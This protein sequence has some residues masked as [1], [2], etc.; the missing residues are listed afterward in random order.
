MVSALA[1][2][3]SAQ[4]SYVAQPG[5]GS[6]FSGKKQDN[7]TVSKANKQE[8][9][10]SS[11]DYTTRTSNW[12]VGIKLGAGQNDPK[13]LKDGFDELTMVDRE[14]DKSAGYFSLEVLHEWAL[15]DEANKIGLK[16]GW[17]V[18]GENELKLKGLSNI[19]EDTY[20][21]PIT[22]YYKRDNGIKNFSW[23]GGAGM[24]IL[25]T[26]LEADGVVD[27]SIS[28]TRVF[29]H[30]TVGGEY[31]FTKVFA[32]GLDARYNFAAKVKK[33]GD[34]LSDRSGFG[35]ALTGRF[36]F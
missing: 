27:D 31:R 29:P 28:K 18:Y 19:T 5:N 25:R 36:Y 34:V 20:A 3:A 4:N 2:S 7:V 21:F 35:A 11:S 32:L 17:D 33:D 9:T 14:L 8:K 16:V 22:V 1:V 26:K 30:I 6:L 12:G 15:N 13:T 23:F 10:S 24:T